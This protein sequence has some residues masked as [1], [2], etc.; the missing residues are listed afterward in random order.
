[1]TERTWFRERAMGWLFLFLVVYA[2]GCVAALAVMRLTGRWSTSAVVSG[3]VAVATASVALRRGE[4]QVAKAVRR[5][6]RALERI[7]SWQWV[8][9]CMLVGAMVR[10]AWGLVVGVGS[11]PDPELY[12][13]LARSLVERGVFECDGVSVYAPPG[14][15]LLLAP[16]FLLPGG[17]RLVPLAPNLL[18]FSLTLWVSHGLARSVAGKGAAHLTTL[19]I[20]AWPNLIMLS[21]RAT[22]ELAVLPL[23]TLVWWLWLDVEPEGGRRVVARRLGAGGLLGLAVLAQPAVLVLAPALAL[24]EVLRRAERRVV[25]ARLAGLVLGAGVVVAPWTVRN[26][27]RF[28]A[29][30]PVSANQG[31]A[32][33]IGNHPGAT[34]GYVPL[35]SRYSD[36]DEVSYD[37]VARRRALAWIRDNPGQFLRLIPVKQALLLGDDAD[38]AWE[39]LRRSR[40]VDPGSYLVAKGISNG[41]WL[42]ILL[43]LALAARSAL[44]C[45]PIDAR[46]QVLMATFLLTL[47][48]FSVSESGGR[49]HVALSAFAAVIA[50]TLAAPRPADGRS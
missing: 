36:M 26:A 11:G 34:G 17:A 45:G 25:A 32:L 38:G 31:H 1:M 40:S 20:A 30:V 43:A 8:V 19:L 4:E 13:G 33:M 15:P 42:V 28:H 14:L 10:L 22:K 39:S 3:A 46:V 35:R 9:A 44:R 12:T 18:F 27:L 5:L 21:A 29:F 24:Y 41:Y 49:H 7:P 23:L 50:A 6:A 37:R 47:I 2:V 16:W 48:P